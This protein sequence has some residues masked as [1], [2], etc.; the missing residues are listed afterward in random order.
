M[1]FQEITHFYL[2]N[3]HKKPNN[4]LI[5]TYVYKWGTVVRE[6]FASTNFR[7]FN[8]RVK[9]FLYK[10]NVRKFPKLKVFHVQE[11]SAT[12]LIWAVVDSRM[13]EFRASAPEA[14][15]VPGYRVYMYTATVL[16]FITAD[17]RGDLVASKREYLWTAGYQ[18]IRSWTIVESTFCWRQSIAVAALIGLNLFTEPCVM[19]VIL[20]SLFIIIRS[21][22]YFAH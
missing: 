5:S 21:R 6:I 8:F 10:V 9:L 17:G 12:D 7:T 2:L 1:C 18:V 20:F 3:H 14:R 22:K 11:P 13:E 4:I 15:G 16:L 19:S